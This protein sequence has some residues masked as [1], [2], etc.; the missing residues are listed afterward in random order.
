MLDTDEGIETFA[1]SCVDFIRQY[2]FDGVDIDFEYPSSTSQSGNPDDF[3]VSE[4][5][6]KT[7]NER[8][9]LMMKTLEKN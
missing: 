1:N 3:D 2:G 5:R 4:P 9:N 6:R 8:Y 7:I